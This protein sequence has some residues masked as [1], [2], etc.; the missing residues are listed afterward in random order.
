MDDFV[1]RSLN[2]PRFLRPVAKYVWNNL[3]DQIE[4]KLRRGR[5]VLLGSYRNPRL[6]HRNHQ[7]KTNNH[8]HARHYRAKTEEALSERKKHRKNGEGK[9]NRSF[10]LPKAR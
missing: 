6:H 4:I 1:H 5:V 9:L 2:S 8:K 10:P 3:K 7:K